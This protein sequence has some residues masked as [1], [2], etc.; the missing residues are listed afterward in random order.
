MRGLL[1]ITWVCRN[2]A[3]SSGLSVRT[4]GLP[5]RQVYADVHRCR[6]RSTLYIYLMPR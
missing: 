6:R 4:L 3:R 2:V 5:T 1:G